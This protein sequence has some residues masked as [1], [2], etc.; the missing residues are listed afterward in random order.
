V[1]ETGRSLKVGHEQAFLFLS[2]EYDNASTRH[3]G[4][5][6]AMR[7]RLRVPGLDASAL[8]H[9]NSSQDAGAPEFFAT[10]A[11]DRRGWPGARTWQTLEGGLTVSC[12][13]DGR[14]TVSMG[15]ELRENNIG[16]VVRAVVPID[17]GQLEQVAADVAAFFAAS[18]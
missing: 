7:A 17:A 8:V 1:S 4:E 5:L 6:W 10:L 15:T 9:L 2:D 3:G 14:G 12:T 18:S 11:A 16:W 13:H